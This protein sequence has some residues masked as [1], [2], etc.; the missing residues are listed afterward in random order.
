MHEYK[1]WV[2]IVSNK[3]RS[4]LYIGV[5]NNLV[6]RIC[7]HKSMEFKGFTCKYKC[8]DL[9]YFEEFQNVKDAIAR[10]KE[11]KGWLRSK[12]DALIATINPELKDLAEQWFL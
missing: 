12:K 4:V 3:T 9:V 1:F 8:C 6:R 5:T 2:Y 11:L 7:E 10:E